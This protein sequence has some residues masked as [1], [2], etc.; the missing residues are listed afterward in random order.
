[1]SLI[2]RS[3]TEDTSTRPRPEVIR[4]PETPTFLE[5]AGRV[6]KFVVAAGLAIVGIGSLAIGITITPF[7]PQAGTGAIALAT[8]LFGIAGYLVYSDAPAPPTSRNVTT[9]T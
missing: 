2:S 6:T 4:P 9:L 5:T 8:T 7:S 3:T 1:M